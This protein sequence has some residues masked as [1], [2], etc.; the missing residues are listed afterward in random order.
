[1]DD[2]DKIPLLPTYDVRGVQLWLRALV[3]REMLWHM[4]DA[5]SECFEDFTPD[6]IATLTAQQEQAWAI[7]N[8]ANVD[9]HELSLSAMNA[10]DKSICRKNP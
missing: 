8:A 9:I 3:A 1:M 4:D 7:C 10:V 6:D 2:I 5:P